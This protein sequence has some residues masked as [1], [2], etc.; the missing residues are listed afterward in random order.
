MTE[1]SNNNNLLLCLAQ[2]PQNCSKAR[3]FINKN[4]HIVCDIMIVDKNINY[5]NGIVINKKFFYRILL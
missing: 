2:D 1:R 4:N 5:N 3:Q